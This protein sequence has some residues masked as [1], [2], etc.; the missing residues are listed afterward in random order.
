[1]LSSC[2]INRDEEY[3]LCGDRVLVKLATKVGEIFLPEDS[4]MR[5]EQ[6]VIVA[7][8]S[9]AVGLPPGFEVG[10]RVLFRMYGGVVVKR[11]LYDESDREARREDEY[12]M[13]IN[14]SDL[15]AL[16]AKKDQQASFESVQKCIDSMGKESK[17]AAA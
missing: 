16:I 4:Q 8:G 12:F 5:E 9:G 6:G 2:S 15:L 10:A 3:L 17:V 7:L 13:I 11:K 1:M 14:C